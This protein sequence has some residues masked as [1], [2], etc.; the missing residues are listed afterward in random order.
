MHAKSTAYMHAAFMHCLEGTA[1]KMLYQ[2]TC[3]CLIQQ[4]SFI[5]TLFQQLIMN[6]KHNWQMTEVS[7]FME[8]HEDNSRSHAGPQPLKQLL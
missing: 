8:Q 1:S 3:K 5:I 4:L 6:Y 2:F 7:N